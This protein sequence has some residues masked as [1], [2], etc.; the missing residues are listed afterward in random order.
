MAKKIIGVIP[1]IITPVD[2]KENVD[3]KGLR[4]LVRR[5]IDHG[6][7]GIFVAGSNG[8][9]MALTQAERDR[10][11]KIVLDET[12][13]AVPVI[14][15]IM[16][17]STRRV[18]E[19]IKRLE[20]MGGKVAVVTPVF[21]ARHATQ[22]ETVRHFEEISKNTN[23]DLMIYNIPPF[24]SQMLK[25]E[26]I[27]KI[28]KIDKVIGYK[29]TSG[30]FPDFIKCLEHFKGT[31]FVLHQGATNLAAASMLLGADGYIPSMAPLY[32]E[33]F[34][35]MYE[36]GKK[37]DIEK[38]MFYDQIISK[39]SSI[40][41]MAKSQTS[42]TKYALSKMGYFHHRVIQPTEPITEAEMKNIDHK[43]EEINAF[44]INNGIQNPKF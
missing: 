39:T 2:E 31:D 24:T 44:L 32:P 25:A 3:E 34:I 17:C 15:G 9:T 6:I 4:K 42:S 7:H 37:G 11:I 20:D 16:D 36:Y 40:W 14:S 30:N 10:A 33:P 22:D 13:D 19:N 29:D 35:K 18:I 26:T 5:C 21:Y 12:K 27:F 23:I 38:T 28:A 8:E 1:P 41:P 43:I